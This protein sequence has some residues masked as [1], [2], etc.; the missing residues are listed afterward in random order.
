MRDTK[1][2]T[3]LFWLVGVVTFVVGLMAP[4]YM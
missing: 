4:F 1:T 2:L 3:R